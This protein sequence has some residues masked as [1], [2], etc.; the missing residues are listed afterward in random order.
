MRLAAAEK[1]EVDMKRIEDIPDAKR[2]REYQGTGIMNRYGRFGSSDTPAATAGERSRRKILNPT[3][4]GVLDYALALAFLAAPGWLGF[5]D[6]A[7]SVSYIIGVTYIAASL[8]T[9]YPLGVIKMIPF[10]VHGVLETIMAACWI[11]MPWVLG[12][13]SDMVA[14]NFYVIAGFGLLLVALLTDYRAT[15]PRTAHAG[16][17]RHHII[18]RRQRSMPVAMDRRIGLA[19][20]RGA[21]YSGA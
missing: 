16:E 20:R 12:Y 21:A 9:K 8:L 2:G 14:R 1:T 4:H 11:V 19:D 18:D 3:I 5:S 6:S 13:A 15:G 17:R 7:A 10:P